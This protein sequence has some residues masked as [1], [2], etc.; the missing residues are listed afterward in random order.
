MYFEDNKETSIKKEAKFIKERRKRRSFTA[1][2]PVIR[3]GTIFSKKH[4]TF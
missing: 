1:Y 4:A 2:G 3:N